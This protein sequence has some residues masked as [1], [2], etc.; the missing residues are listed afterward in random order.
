[1][2]RW[3]SPERDWKSVCS[4]GGPVI[5][6]T[7]FA[8][9]AFRWLW[10]SSLASATASGM[11]ITAT[12]WLAVDAGGGFGVGVA[13]AA[14]LLPSLF[15]G[16]VAGALAD[17]IDRTRQLVAVSLAALPLTLGLSGL[18][19]TGS[20]PLWL[21]AVLTFGVGCLTVFDVPARQALAVDVVPRAIA[22]NA[23]ALNAVATRL[24][25]ALGAFTAGI[26][27]PATG[28][29]GCYVVAVCAFAVGGALV[30]AVRPPAPVRSASAR[31]A[32]SRAIV[33]GLQLIRDLPAV[34]TLV[35]AG[36]ACEIFGFSF[37][38]AVPVVARDVLGAGVEGLGTLSAA[39][40]IGG[41]AAVLL[42]S[43]LPGGVRREPFLGLVFVTYGM[44]MLVLAGASSLAAAA[45]V[46]VVTGACAAA[47]DLLQQTLLQL[48]VPEDQ[49]GRAVGVWVLGIGTGPVGHLE[50]GSLL[51]VLGAP[52]A[53]MLN[54]VIVVAAALILVVRMPLFRWRQ[55]VRS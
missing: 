20:V 21:L 13:L 9:R 1:M 25:T 4:Y 40:S 46:L 39:A 38:T 28:V 12:A 23:M 6:L 45:L 22:P 52:S 10:A 34:R 5:A 31:P 30:L 15:F 48:A 50:M 44:S 2:G 33:E 8:S 51:T 53:L 17:R 16:L 32:L 54:G 11:L 29:A 36:I 26:L 49:R 35:A 37:Q 42:L 27:I 47:F 24:C 18:A 43:L 14:R 3:C 55:M 7:P 41:T 19:A